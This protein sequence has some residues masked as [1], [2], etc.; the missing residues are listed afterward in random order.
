MAYAKFLLTLHKNLQICKIM[1]DIKRITTAEKELYEYVEGLLVKS[2][3]KNEYRELSE[4]RANTDGKAH[5]HNNVV[6]ND[7]QPIGLLTY[8]DFGTFCYVE[9]FAID[10]GKRNGGFGNSVLRQICGDLGKPVV[11]EVEMPEEEMSRRRIGFYQRNGFVLWENN[12]EQ[13][14]YR[15]G[16]D[17]L[18]MLLMVYGPL[19]SDGDY[20]QIRRCIYRN[21]YNI[22][23]S[24]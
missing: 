1:I 14:P 19:D 6:L 11:L 21:I 13:P 23:E 17:F 2:F 24:N 8:W 20:E 16:D 3:P 12:Y 10:P 15:P 18:P 7:G 9:H 4:Q 5:F 22:P